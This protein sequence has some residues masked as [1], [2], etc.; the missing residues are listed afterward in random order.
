MD[1]VYLNNMVAAYFLMYFGKWPFGIGT[2]GN[3]CKLFLIASYSVALVEY[4]RL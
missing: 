2:S 1:L 3:C 4:G